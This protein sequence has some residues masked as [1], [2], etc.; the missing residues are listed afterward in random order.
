MMQLRSYKKKLL[1]YHLK[2]FNNECDQN[3]QE[4][5]SKLLKNIDPESIDGIV[6]LANR[7]ASLGKDE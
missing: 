3:C 7:K 4:H 1:N 5:I 2:K 6:E